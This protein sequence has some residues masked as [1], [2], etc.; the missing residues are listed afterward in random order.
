MAARN[1]NANRM[2]SGAMLVLALGLS[3]CSENDSAAN[4]AALDNSLTNNVTDP[5]LQGALQDQI[6][7]DPDL[8]GQ[9]NANAVRPAD[10][11][12]NGALPAAT[13]GK[14]VADVGPLMRAPAPVE[15]KATGEAPVTLG[16]MAREQG[17][18]QGS[19]VGCATKLDYNMAWAN[20]MPVEFP[21]YPGAKLT[22]AAGIANADCNVR[23]A[24]FLVTTPLQGV[25]DYYYT[26][27]K[28]AG[29]GVSHE[30]INGEQV[31]GGTRASDDGAFVVSFTPQSGGGVDVAIIANNGR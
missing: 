29:Y 23:A 20:R 2:F 15:T 17:K 31:L 1:F 28:R 6:V 30:R 8:V 3:A 5:A 24:S 27:A 11:P 9:S 7:V 18:K 10:R 12:M 19:G 16:A 14:S 21:V 4:L 25:V 13:G 22:E 26:L